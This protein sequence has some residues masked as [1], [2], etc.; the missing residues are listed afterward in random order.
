MRAILQTT[1]SETSQGTWAGWEG[2]PD[3]V[4]HSAYAT[5][6]SQRDDIETEGDYA[7]VE[8]MGESTDV[9]QGAGE[10]TT[11]GSAKE[12]DGEDESVRK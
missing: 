5:V 11:G 12:K 1:F 8:T 3:Q 2:V 10:G 7:E 4:W 9:S 6:S